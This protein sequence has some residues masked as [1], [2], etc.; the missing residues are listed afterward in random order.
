MHESAVEFLRRELGTLITTPAV[1]VETCFFLDALGKCAFLNWIGCGGLELFEVP[2]RDYSEITRY[3]DK[4]SDQDIDFADA[5]LVWLANQTGDREILTV[6]E[7]DFSIYRLK[8][9]KRFHL[10]SWY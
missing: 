1:V 8:G 6:D 3:I 9:N 5:A 7:T 2:T 10:V 4:Y